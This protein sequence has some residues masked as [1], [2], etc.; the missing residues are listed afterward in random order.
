MTYPVTPEFQTINVTSRNFTRKSES[1]SG[2]ISVRANPSQRWEMTASYD[3]LTKSE[4]GIINAFIVSQGGEY[5]FFDLIP[6]EISSSRGSNPAGTARVN[7]AHTAGDKTILIDGLL[8]SLLKGDFVTFAG[9]TKVYMLTE[10]RAGAGTM[11]IYPPL[12]ANVP[13]NAIITYNNV[14]FK[15]RLKNSVQSYEVSAN[16]QYNVEV[17]FVEEI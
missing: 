10:D 3:R 14:P 6:T 13:N 4:V 16:N 17:D 15:V 12:V 2:K 9:H 1:L 11:T 8:N 5:G 7:G